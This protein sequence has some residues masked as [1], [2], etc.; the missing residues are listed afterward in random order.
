MAV[1]RDRKALVGH[2]L[3][4]FTYVLDEENVRDYLSVSGED[5]AVY[6]DAQAS[7]ISGYDDRVIPPS[8]APWVALSAMLRSIDWERDF[9]FDYRTGTSMFGEQEMI[10]ARPL[11]VNE[12]LIFAGTVISVMEKQGSRAFDL[13]TVGYRAVDKNKAVALRGSCAFILFK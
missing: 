8:F 7:R 13:V 10:Y 4:S 9:Y 11:Y 1:N 5:I 3:P 6:G 2:V 12:T